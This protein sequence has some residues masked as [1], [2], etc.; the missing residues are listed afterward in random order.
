MANGAPP[1]TEILQALAQAP[2][3]L[4]NLGIR[5]VGE[6]NATFGLG[7]QRLAAGLAVP[8]LPPMTQ[9]FP[10]LPSLPQ[11][12]PS[13]PAPPVP[14]GQVAASAAGMGFGSEFAEA[15]RILI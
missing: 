4:M 12:L 5:H 11:G 6:L 3:D 9:G 7:M 14:T 15:P 8:P 2:I 10:Q 13:L 1:G